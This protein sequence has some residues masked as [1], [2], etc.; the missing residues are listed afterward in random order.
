LAVSSAIRASCGCFI[1]PVRAVFVIRPIAGLYRINER[2]HAIPVSAQSVQ[3]IWPQGT[4]AGYHAI[5]PISVALPLFREEIEM[6]LILIIILV[7][8]LVGAFPAWPYSSGWGY[9]PSSGLGLV[10]IVVVVLLLMG[11]I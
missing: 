10:L 8:L 1:V 3:T 11:R 7:L 9:Y 2:H 4:N 5:P 6:G